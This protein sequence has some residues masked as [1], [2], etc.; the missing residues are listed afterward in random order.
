MD[1]QVEAVPDSSV[2]FREKLRSLSFVG[3]KTSSKTIVDHTDT[4]V[5]HTTVKDE[6]QDVR[7]VMN[8]AVRPHRPEMT[9]AYQDQKRKEQS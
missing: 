5:V 1:L 7:V 8:D 3:K 2:E 9:K 4:A 6:S